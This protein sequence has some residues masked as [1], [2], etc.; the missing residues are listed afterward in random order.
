MHPLSGALSF[1]S[2]LLVHPA[3]V[4]HGALVANRNSF[5]PPRCK[6]YQHHKTFVPISVSLWNYLSNPVFDGVGL[7]GF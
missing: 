7:A 5:A 1:R 6:N 4:T 3:R 2:M